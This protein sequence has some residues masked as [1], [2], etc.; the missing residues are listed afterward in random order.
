MEDEIYKVNKT[1]TVKIENDTYYQKYCKYQ[2]K[3]VPVDELKYLLK[4]FFN[5]AAI[6]MG[7]DSYDMPDNT[8]DAILEFTMKDFKFIPIMYVGSAI[9]K[10]SLGKSDV[11]GRLV[12]RTIYGWLNEASLEYNKVLE[13]EKYKNY[14]SDMS[15]TFDLHK[16]PVGSAIIKKM[17]WLK[18]GVITEDEWD[19]IPLK[20]L[21]ERIGQGLESVPEI[22]GIKSN[23]L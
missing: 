7:K 23:K 11:K 2:I 5:K 20:D 19:M 1:K 17:D 8:I 6:N 22:F 12:P 16:Y 9:I 3:D 15:L 10:G 4:L 18:S 14:N 13:K 21:A